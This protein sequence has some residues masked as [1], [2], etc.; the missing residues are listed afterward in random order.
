MVNQ[1]QA[2]A[3]PPN[4]CSTP[5]HTAVASASASVD[6]VRALLDGGADINARDD[7]N[8]SVLAEAVRSDSTTVE[9]LRLLLDRGAHVNIPD[10]AATSADH[11]MAPLEAAVIH[12]R[13]QAV[14]LLLE[15]GADP[16]ARNHDG[17]TAL[18]TACETKLV[19]VDVVRSLLDGGADVNAVIPT[20]FGYVI[21]QNHTPLHMAS[22]NSKVGPELIRLLLDRGADV[23]A[24]GCVLGCTPLHCSLGHEGVDIEVVRLLLDRGANVNAALK[25][26][27][28]CLYDRTPLHIACKAPSV[29]IDLIRLLLDR[30]AN[31][32]APDFR[33][34]PPLHSVIRVHTDMSVV[35]LLLDRGADVCICD[36]HVDGTAFTYASMYSAS[37]DIIC[38]LLERVADVNVKG[39]GI[40]S[41]LDM[42]TGGKA[43]VAR[44]LL[45]RGADMNMIDR[46]KRTLLHHAISGRPNAS[47]GCAAVVR[48]LLDRGAA[49]DCRDSDGY[50]PL[51]KALR[52]SAAESVVRLLLDR[53]A[54]A[55]ARA[56]VCLGLRR[57]YCRMATRPS[58]SLQSPRSKAAQ[59]PMSPCC[60]T[61]MACTRESQVMAEHA[62]LLLSHGKCAGSL[63]DAI[64]SMS[65]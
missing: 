51:H 30:G 56:L 21:Q 26:G 32:N 52:K 42:V 48:L 19:S 47:A 54:S 64:V 63:Y 14:C 12:K 45:D 6:A 4:Q 29:N 25:H 1:I 49:I 27:A 33:G 34:A 41:L 16:S 7:K 28:K 59:S 58:I 15:R 20:G 46:K 38:K 55:M 57:S 44:M 60:S 43:N 9:I 37:E 10:I 24:D 8:Q 11:P 17:R 36:D 39:V 65:Q 22:L 61:I 13:A 31:V 35:A 50:T 18:H 5:L 53:G 3:I 40:P 62:F 2:M 23:N